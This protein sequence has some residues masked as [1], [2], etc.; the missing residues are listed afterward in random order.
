MEGLRYEYMCKSL[1]AYPDR[2]AR[3]V[4]AFPNLADD[5]VAGRWLL[6]SPGSLLCLSSSV[7]REA[8][9][10]HLCLPSPAVETF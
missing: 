5:K 2:E 10:A 7:V 9:S 6:A 8:L 3:P 4:T 1:D